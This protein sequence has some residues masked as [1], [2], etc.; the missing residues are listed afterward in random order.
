MTD[1]GQEGWR[2]AVQAD[3]APSGSSTQQLDAS[4]MQSI[5]QAQLASQS[6]T[7]SGF[8]D[9]HRQTQQ[10][11]QGMQALPELFCHNH[12]ANN[13]AFVQLQV[14]VFATH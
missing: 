6:H 11:H 10:Q 4:C 3:A 2:Q 8:T 14:T 5:Q 13:G 9:S 7:P 12:W 1:A